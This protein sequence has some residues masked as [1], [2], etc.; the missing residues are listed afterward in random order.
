MRFGNAKL[1]AIVELQDDFLH[2]LQSTDFQASVECLTSVVARLKQTFRFRPLRVFLVRFS[3]G[4]S[5]PAENDDGTL[6][7]RAS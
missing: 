5:P 4:Q 1:P 2:T 6:E 7:F 3:S